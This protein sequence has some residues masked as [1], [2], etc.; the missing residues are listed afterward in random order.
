MLQQ[1]FWSFSGPYIPFT[2]LIPYIQSNP[3]RVNPSIS[4]KS[5]MVARPSPIITTSKGAHRIITI[6]MERY[7]FINNKKGV[8]M[9]QHIQYHPY[10][11][12]CFVLTL[13][14]LDSL[15]QVYQ[16]DSHSQ[17]C[18]RLHYR[19]NDTHTTYKTLNITQE[20]Y[21]DEPTHIR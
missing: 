2:L 8:H 13:F 6:N 17:R 16:Q 7:H 4:K 14:P 11:M 18:Y 1:C 10:C 9:H 3:I 19:D 12:L 15:Q 5:L 20:Y 21:L